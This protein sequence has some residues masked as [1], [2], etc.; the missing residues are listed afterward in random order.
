MNS[1]VAVRKRR[2]VSR[3]CTGL[4]ERRRVCGLYAV[5]E[6]LPN[7]P[8]HVTPNGEMATRSGR[9][10]IIPSFIVNAFFP[11]LLFVWRLAVN[12]VP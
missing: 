10:A 7:P 3:I 2:R 11:L 6:F 8:S 1:G 9:A 5:Y 4:A 12:K